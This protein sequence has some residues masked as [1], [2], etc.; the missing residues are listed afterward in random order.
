MHWEH[1]PILV[2]ARVLQQKG[3]MLE[4]V[5]VLLKGLFRAGFEQRLN[6]AWL[7]GVREDPN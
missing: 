2:V 6:S 3:R 7:P 1:C 4:R 5:K